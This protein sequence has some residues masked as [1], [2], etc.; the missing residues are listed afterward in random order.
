VPHVCPSKNKLL[1]PPLTVCG[2]GVGVQESSVSTSKEMILDDDRG[3][4]FVFT[5]RS[6]L[7]FH[8]E[9]LDVYQLL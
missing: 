5:R 8:K 3:L 2:G 9:K 6:L 4:L 1:A 7:P